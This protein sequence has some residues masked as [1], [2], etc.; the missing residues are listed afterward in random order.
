[1]LGISPVELNGMVG[2]T[3]DYSI[4]KQNEDIKPHVDQ[5][6]FQTQVENRVEQSSSTVI[7]GQRTDTDGEGSGSG[8]YGG[9]GGRHRKKKNSVPDEGLVI[10]KRP[11]GFDVSI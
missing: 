7:Q 10:K 3:Q 9:D 4:V 8:G 11:G 1:M 5:G 6:N 2:R